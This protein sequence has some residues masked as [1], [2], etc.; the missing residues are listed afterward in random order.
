MKVCIHPYIAHKVAEEG[1]FLQ[2]Q[3]QYGGDRKGLN[4]H[5]RLALPIL[6]TQVGTPDC[7]S[8]TSLLSPKWVTKFRKVHGFKISFCL[9][10][11]GFVRE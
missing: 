10:V 2:I 3:I 1:C 8:S 4:S 9:C 5:G 7:Y 11:Y 6:V